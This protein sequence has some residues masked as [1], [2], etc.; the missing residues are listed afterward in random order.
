MNASA[1]V[2]ELPALRRKAAGLATLVE[3]SGALASTL[4]LGRILQATTDGVCRLTAF[5]TAAV[6]LLD[7]ETLR[8]GAT[9]PALPPDF[10]EPLRL[11]PLADHPHIRGALAVGAPLQLPD[12]REAQ[13]T[14]AERVAVEQ[15]GLRTVLY[16][17]MIAGVKPVG[18]LIVSDGAVRP[19]DPDEVDLCRTLANLAALATENA[20]LYGRGQAA[21]AEKAR[22]DAARHEMERRLLHAQK[23]ESLGLLAG[24][25]AHDFNNLLQ[26]MLGNLDLARLDLPEGA[27]ARAAVEDAALAA[28]RAR[29]LTRQLLAYS[30]R[31]RFVVR[32]TDL[33]A[34]VQENARL[35]RS[36]V[37]RTC[38]IELHLADGLPPVEADAGQL[39]QVVMNLLTN[40]A[41]AVGG[42]PGTITVTTALRPDAPDL[43]AGGRTGAVPPSP[44]W[45]VLEVRDTG[46]G[47][48]Q[49]TQ[50]RMFDPFFSTKGHGR[51]LGMAALL[52]IVRGHRGTIQ[53]ESAPGAGATVRVLLPTASG[54]APAEAAGP[55]P[56]V[57]ATPAAGTVLVVDDEELVRRAGLSM[58]RALG[59]PALGAAGGREAVELVRS[60]PGVVGTVLLDL[61]MPDLDGLATLD[62]LH[63][64]DP[65]LRV[66]LSSGFDAEES[67]R[68]SAGRRVAGFLQK[69]FTVAA[70]RQAL[71]LPPRS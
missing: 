38:A 3:V 63:A 18:V 40:A 34:L 60:R 32:P 58:M 16:T 14:P 46:C 31:G 11:A 23:L 5:D 25:I 26:A 24:G 61:T 28:S 7:G 59:L 8:L 20:R 36:G 70:L 12:V 66:I 2:Q 17:P 51:G 48:D 15:R 27:A 67:L 42:R 39:Q 44:A 65:S 4:D 53:V 21:A 69:P 13:L 71:G 62:A 47:M 56:L 55:G 22:A 45:V 1:A 29:D 30:G 33:T 37:P 57:Q 64:L 54:A 49:A 52:G 50:D 6:Y 35:F 10:P 43:L 19:L 41:D 68:R 9:S